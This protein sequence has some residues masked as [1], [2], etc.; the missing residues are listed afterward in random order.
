MLFQIKPYIHVENTRLTFFVTEIYNMPIDMIQDGIDSCE[1]T[2]S[3][4]QS[5]LSWGLEVSEIYIGK[6]VSS[7]EYNSSFKMEIPT[8]ELLEMLKK[9]KK[10]LA[11][12]S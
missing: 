11:E 10:A 1:L 8:K 5:N 4:E 3:G 7:L 2:I 9:Y 12:W 6:E